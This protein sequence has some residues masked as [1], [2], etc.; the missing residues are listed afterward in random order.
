MKPRLGPDREAALS[1]DALHLQLAQPEPEF[2]AAVDWDCIIRDAKLNRLEARVL[3][4]HWRRGVPFYQLHTA[5]DCTKAETMRAYDRVLRKL[6]GAGGNSVGLRPLKHSLRPAFREP[7]RSGA[8]PWSLAS[9]GDEFASVMHREKYIHLISQRHP[10]DF[11]KPIVFCPRV[12]GENG[13]MATVEIDLGRELA[14]AQTR[15][16]ELAEAHAIFEA[17]V[18]RLRLELWQS[19]QVAVG[20]DARPSEPVSGDALEAAAEILLKDPLADPDAAL[21]LA[22]K[23]LEVRSRAAEK[24]LEISRAATVRQTIVVNAL[25]ERVKAANYPRVEAQAKPLLV[26]ALKLLG[27]LEQ[28]VSALWRVGRSEEIELGYSQLFPKDMPEDVKAAILC[29]LR[30]VTRVEQLEIN[31]GVKTRAA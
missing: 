2:S 19:T 29:L 4:H 9:L 26:N 18:K 21:G 11:Q 31:Y 25:V 10:E 14:T 15:R 27:Q 20:K 30:H 7:L 8:R 24:R 13:K 6:R 3:T 5:L 1:L 23:S 28:T 12:I 16:H 22:G 17:D